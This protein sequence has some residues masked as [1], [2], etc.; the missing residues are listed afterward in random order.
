MAVR[1]RRR[2]S[3]PA[4]LGGL[5]LAGAAVALAAVALAPRHGGT[6][7]SPAADPALP[8]PVTPA[9]TPGA[10]RPLGSL[11]NLS[12]WA[13]VEHDALAR[14]APTRT[15]RVIASLG[16]QTPEGT[17]NIV[18]VLADRVARG[19]RVWVHVGLAVLPNGTTAWVPRAALG[20]YVTVDTRLDVDLERLQATL[21]RAGRRG[22][23]VPIGAGM[24]GWATPRGTFYVRN[25]LSRYRSPQYG[26]VAFGT[27]ARSPHATDW[28]AGG[29]VGIH[30]TDRPDLIPGRVSHGCIRLR[31][32]DV[33]RLARQ[34][35]VG[36]PVTIH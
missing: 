14:V 19:G 34:M 33:L 27:S 17:R 29:F 15:A 35:P 24:A 18:A 36:T 26:P 7:G 5:A 32:A 28:P 11:R 12:H 6:P 16:T 23:R 4:A 21:Y 3:R 31:N 22:L 30:G 2:A 25:R 20:G 1:R 8:A 10:P 13:P 9:F